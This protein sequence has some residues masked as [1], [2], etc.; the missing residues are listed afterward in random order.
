MLTV[1]TADRAVTIMFPLKSMRL[2]MK[3]A[4]YVVACGWI[5]CFFLTIL[6]ATGIPYF[7]DS[8]FGRTGN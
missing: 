5:T 4:R 6:P 2:R 7:G 8:F 3:G 1:I